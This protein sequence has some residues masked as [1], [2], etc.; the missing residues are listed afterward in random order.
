M[1]SI[2][3]RRIV[4]LQGIRYE[5]SRGRRAAVMACKKGKALSLFLLGE[6]YYATVIHVSYCV[7]V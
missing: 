1:D 6:K 5:Q 2:A 3:N 7:S 4:G